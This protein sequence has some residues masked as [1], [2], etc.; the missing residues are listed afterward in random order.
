MIAAFAAAMASCGAIALAWTTVEH[1]SPL[2]WLRYLAF[3]ATREYS[4]VAVLPSATRFW[5]A[6]PWAVTTTAAAV[7]GSLALAAWLS[8]DRRHGPR[9]DASVA[10]LVL[11]AAWI[12]LVVTMALFNIT[13]GFAIYFGV[14]L[15]AV[16][17]AAP[18]RLTSAHGRR[19]AAG[20]RR[21][22]RA[23]PA[24]GP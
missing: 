2:R 20:R 16:V 10:S 1:G 14:P 6:V 5:W 23:T 12:N 19:G 24:S 9:L 8:A 15:L 3:I 21:C 17:L 7:V 13:F 11:T 18:P 22:S 4:D